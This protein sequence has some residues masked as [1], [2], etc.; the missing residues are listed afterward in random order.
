MLRKKMAQDRGR[1]PHF[2]RPEEAVKAKQD[3]IAGLRRHVAM[4]TRTVGER[5]IRQPDKLAQ[6]ADYIRTWF[7]GLGLPARKQSYRYRGVEVSNIVAR[8]GS[9]TYPSRHYVLGAHY[10]AVDGTVGADDNASAVAVLMETARAAREVVAVD[11]QDMGITFAAFTMEESPAF[12]TRFMGSRVFAAEARKKAI[13]IEGMIC[14]EMVGYTCREPGCQRYP[15]PLQ[16]MRYPKT[17][18]FIG[19]VGNMKSA[20]FTRGLRRSFEANPDLPV[21]AL[22]VPLNGWLM[23]NVRLSDHASFWNYGYRAVMVTDSAFYRNPHYHLPSDTMETL[24]YDFM[25][26]LVESLT[27]YF[28][29]RKSGSAASL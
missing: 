8:L 18:D 12:G 15:F 19:I 6:A 21:V 9:T 17:G 23:P 10:D 13:R 24:D 16:F 5:S 11:G 29:S 25:A 14:L 4:L 3:T 1:H 26:E 27:G 2:F 28:G 7:E 22:T 20:S